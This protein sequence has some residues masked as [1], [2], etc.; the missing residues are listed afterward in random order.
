MHCFICSLNIGLSLIRDSEIYKAKLKHNKKVTLLLL[1]V[2]IVLK[3]L[4]FVFLF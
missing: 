2:F 3:G 1:N 4:N